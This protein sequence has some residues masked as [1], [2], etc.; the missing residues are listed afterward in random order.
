MACPAFYF[1]FLIFMMEHRVAIMRA[2]LPGRWLAPDF[3]TY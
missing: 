3:S 1:R 2:E